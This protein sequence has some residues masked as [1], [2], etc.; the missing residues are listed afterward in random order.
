M[1][2][3]SPDTCKC[4]C[5]VEKKQL[6]KQCTTHTTYEQTLK[7]NQDENLKY[8]RSP[9]KTQIDTIAIQKLVLYTESRLR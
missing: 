5:D 8:G 7:A 3:W 1:T 2:I 6:I 4:V 9:T